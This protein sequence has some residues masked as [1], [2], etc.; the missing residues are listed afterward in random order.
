MSASSSSSSFLQSCMLLR[1]QI[2]APAATGI[3]AVASTSWG[4]R[5]L[6][7][8]L[9]AKYPPMD[10]IFPSG[11]S[12]Q[13]S[14]AAPREISLSAVAHPI[15]GDPADPQKLAASWVTNQLYGGTAD[16]VSS[17]AMAMYMCFR[18]NG[19]N[20]ACSACDQGTQWLLAVQPRSCCMY[21]GWSLKQGRMLSMPG[22]LLLHLVHQ[23][24]HAS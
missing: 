16:Q 3:S 11:I 12:P 18:A 7:D 8:L 10:P 4:S 15:L 22:D 1:I 9:K 2:Q 5:E 21:M 23:R 17:F 6:Q 14:P 13:D 20:I 19:C 24:I